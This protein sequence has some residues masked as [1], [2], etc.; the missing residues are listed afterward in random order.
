MRFSVDRIF[1][2]C[3]NQISIAHPGQPNIIKHR[4]LSQINQIDSMGLTNCIA[5]AGFYLAAVA[6]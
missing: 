6:I 3:Y 2:I 5:A 1:S 4:I